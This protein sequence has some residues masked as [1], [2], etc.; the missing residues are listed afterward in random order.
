MSLALAI[1][2]LWLGA[3]L[4]WVAFTGMSKS[5]QKSES[6]AGQPSDVVTTLHTGIMAQGSA[7]A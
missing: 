5:P 3:A 4:L 7:Y 1:L 2:F 6:L